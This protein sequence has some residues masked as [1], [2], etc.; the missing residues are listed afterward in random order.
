M[1]YDEEYVQILKDCIEKLNE[2][3]YYYRK[4]WL[5]ACDMNEQ[6]RELITEGAKKDV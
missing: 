5:L 1:T 3:I 2:T 4:L 6:Y